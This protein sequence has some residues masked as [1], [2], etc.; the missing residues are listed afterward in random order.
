MKLTK[1][2]DYE[3]GS[4]MSIEVRNK[5]SL[6]HIGL[7]HTEETLKKI[8]ESSKGRIMP[9]EAVLKRNAKLR[10]QK[11]TVEFKRKMSATKKGTIVSLETGRKISK[12]LKGRKMSQI[13]KDKIG[14]KSKGRKH[15]EQTKKNHSIVMKKKWEDPAYA[16]KMFKAYA[17]KPTKPELQMEALL[18]ELFPKEYKYVG[19]GDVW[20]AGKCPDFINCNGQKKIIEVYGDYWHK[21]DNPQ[22][23]IDIFEPYGYQTL[24]IWA[25]EIDD[26]TNY[27]RNEIKKF[28]LMEH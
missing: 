21:D 15:T 3:K 20:I 13:H 9:R 10:G 17:M 1:Q 22:D 12:A 24:V 25:S 11:R 27:V 23:R 28:H 26:G 7:R 18:N 5:M 2:V 16:K 6:A 14:L 8:S 19:D 4:K